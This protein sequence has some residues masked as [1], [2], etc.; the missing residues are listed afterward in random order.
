MQNGT[1]DAGALDAA[2]GQVNSGNEQEVYKGKLA[3]RRAV[4]A[5]G[6]PGRE[7]ERAE[8]AAKLAA[9]L[10]DG[11]TYSA[12]ARCTIAEQLADVGGDAEVPALEAALGDL[13]VR[14]AARWALDRIPTAAA[15]AA[16]V[17]SANESIGAR[18][19]TGL[20]NSLGQRT[21]E[22]VVEALKRWAAEDPLME[23]RLAAAEALA[24]HPDPTS[25]A[26]IMKVMEGPL[27]AQEKGRLWKASLRLAGTVAASGNKQAAGR[28]FRAIAGGSGPAPQKKAAQAA[29]EAL[30]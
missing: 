13:E 23:V 3:L 22:G 19:R 26:V 5:A 6:A 21:G 7:A 14:G 8:V 27:T 18:Y 29:A 2:L 4:A 24:N 17:K 16:L 20:M 12:R 15:T 1:V 30:S 25:Y 28:M 11:K 10:A 9:A